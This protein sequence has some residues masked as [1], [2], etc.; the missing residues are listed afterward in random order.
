ME[1]GSIGN[2][3]ASFTNNWPNVAGAAACRWINSSSHADSCAASQ[4]RTSTHAMGWKNNSQVTTVGSQFHHR[5]RRLR[6]ASSC[7][8]ISR[9]SSGANALETSRGKT[10]VGRNMPASI[11]PDAPAANFI[12]GSRAIPSVHASRWHIALSVLSVT[13]I[14]SRQRHP[15]VRQWRSVTITEQTK[16]TLHSATNTVAQEMP[17]SRLLAIASSRLD[18][19]RPVVYGPVR[20]TRRIRRALRRKGAG[21]GKTGMAIGGS[22]TSDSRIFTHA[23]RHSQHTTRGERK[24]QTRT[25]SPHASDDQCRLPRRSPQARA[26][27]SGPI[28]QRNEQLVHGCDPCSRDSMRL[29]NSVSLLASSSLSADER[30][31]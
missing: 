16:P 27:G 24:V 26:P 19:S 2:R 1:R 4:R 11:G 7:A 31:R 8:I 30:V 28:M 10:I 12:R 23:S 6:C 21:G 29:S 25:I 17:A 3:P 9:C 5:L 15:V 22:Q 14:A 13:S 20:G 18:A